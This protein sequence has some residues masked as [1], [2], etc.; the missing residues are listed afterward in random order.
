M[1]FIFAAIVCAA[2]APAGA[3]VQYQFQIIHAFGGPGDGIASGGGMV[4]DGKGNLY[5]T[6]EG[7]GTQGG[8]GTVYELSPSGNGQWTETILHSFPVMDPLDGREPNGLVMDGAG[9]LYGTT[10]FDGDGQYCVGYITCGTV[11][12]LSPGANGEWTET[13]VWNFCSLPDCADGGNPFVAPT[14]GPGGS[15]YGV[16]GSVAYRLVPESGGWTLSVLNTF[17]GIEPNCP[18]GSQPSSPLTLDG[19]GNLYG[20][21]ETGGDCSSGDLGCGVVYVL[22]QQT[23][24]QWEE[25]VLHDFQK[26]GGD[27]G[28]G[29]QGGLSFHDGGLYGV[30]EAGGDGCA[31]GCGTAFELM[32]GSGNSINEQIVWNFGGHGGA[33]GVT[34]NGGVAFNQQGDLFGVTAGGGESGGYGI[35]YGMGLRKNGEW[36]FQVLHT[37]DGSDGVEPL[38]RLAIDSQG[39]L[40]GV[41]GGGGSIGG[42]VAFELSPV[43]QASK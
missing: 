19:A 37:F 23:N 14:V 35:V 40:Y 4:L 11:F 33:Q 8:G 42:G 31:L 9:N 26:S 12:E 30:T 25:I 1:A 29:P 43:K 28:A 38:G 6:T 41:A 17:C 5:G 27:D 39:N 36:A 13:I 10:E 2:P 34:P 22:H 18:T 15:L 20:E 32:R 7:G 3:Q 16:A 21:T 24:G